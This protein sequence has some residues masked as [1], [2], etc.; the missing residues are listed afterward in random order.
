MD[1]L[2]R[3]FTLPK[4]RNS[5]KDLLGVEVW[6]QWERDLDRIEGFYRACARYLAEHPENSERFVHALL[7]LATDNVRLL[8]QGLTTS[9]PFY[10]VRAN[11]RS[12]ARAWQLDW[13]G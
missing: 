10:S 8:R 1:F 7:M 5:V 3:L 11:A 2:R 9:D 6:Q 13:S 12:F 4:S